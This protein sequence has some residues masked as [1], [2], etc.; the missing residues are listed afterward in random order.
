[1][2]E[3][4]L[5]QKD[6]EKY[7]EYK[8]A[9]RTPRQS[10]LLTDEELNQKITLADKEAAARAKYRKPDKPEKPDKVRY[11]ETWIYNP[12]GTKRVPA[13]FNPAT[14]VKEP[15]SKEWQKVP[16][17]KQGDGEGEGSK[18]TGSL[19]PITPGVVA[20]IKAKTKTKEEAESLARSMGYDPERIA[21]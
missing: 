5:Y 11:Q 4:E 21:Q 7:K 6:P 12:D 14:G 19:K 16:N 18:P 2:T 8:E 10:K 3:M 9:G 15:L 17:R 13:R 20:Q 1:M